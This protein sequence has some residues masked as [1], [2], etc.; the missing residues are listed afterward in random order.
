MQKGECGGG[1]KIPIFNFKFLIIKYGYL[2]IFH[3]INKGLNSS[4]GLRAAQ[5]FGLGSNRLLATSL[6]SILGGI[7]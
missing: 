6:S 5:N 7:D 4:I 1:A 2:F 3:T